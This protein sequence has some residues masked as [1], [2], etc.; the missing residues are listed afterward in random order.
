M[1]PSVA[2]SD[3]PGARVGIDLGSSSPA[4]KIASTHL[5]ISNAQD[6][7]SSQAIEQPLD[8]SAACCTMSGR[9]WSVGPR[10]HKTTA[11]VHF[12]IV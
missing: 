6:R 5:N 1:A 11:R 10:D 7:D 4:L 3:I 9:T 12:S 8:E 2:A